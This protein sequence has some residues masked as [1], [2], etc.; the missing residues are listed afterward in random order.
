M[1]ITSS[2]ARK[3]AL[4][5]G[6]GGIGALGFLAVRRMRRAISHIGPVT[7]SVTVN[8]PPRDVY[9]FFRDFSRLPE[10]MD[11]LDS[12]VEDGEASTWTANLPVAGKVT[13]TADIVDDVPGK[14]ISWQSRPGSAVQTRGRVTFTKAPGREMT[15]V[16]VEMQLGALGKRPSAAIA[17]L[18]AEP[19]VKGDMRRFKQVLETGEVLRSD[20]SAHRKPHPAQPSLDAKPAPPLFIPHPATAV[21]GAAS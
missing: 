3:L 9:E 6:V 12:V 18:F 20:A 4:A 2:P 8:K 10:F 17:R 21:K 11:Y 13:W 5:L 16:R 19:Q 15:E 14:L 1:F 7:A